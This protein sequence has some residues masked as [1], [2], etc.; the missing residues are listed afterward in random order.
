MN[1][2]NPLTMMVEDMS[3]LPSPLDQLPASL[4]GVP[5]LSFS[6]PVPN[7]TILSS[8]EGF[9]SGTTCFSSTSAILILLG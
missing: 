2:L 5:I 1:V 3:S 8:F 4:S 6:C 9:F 7:C